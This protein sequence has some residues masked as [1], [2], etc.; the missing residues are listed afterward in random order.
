MLV[1][2]RCDV[3][4]DVHAVYY[5]VVVSGVALMCVV[6]IFYVVISK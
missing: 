5:G 3:R 6:E 4:H 2:R 1:H